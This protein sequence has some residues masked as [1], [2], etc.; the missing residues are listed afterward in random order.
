MAKRGASYDANV[1][2]LVPKSM[3]IVDN[4]KKQEIGE[5][6]RSIYLSSNQKFEDNLGLTI[7]VSF[8]KEIK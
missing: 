1:K 2:K 5:K 6:I 8:V 4:A 3:N 7:A